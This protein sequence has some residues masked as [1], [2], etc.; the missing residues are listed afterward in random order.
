M[1]SAT[2]TS[3]LSLSC[4]LLRCLNLTAKEGFATTVA[5]VLTARLGLSVAPDLSYVRSL[6][7]VLL[8]GLTVRYGQAALGVERLYIYLEELEAVLSSQVGAGFKR[9]GEAY[10]DYDPFFLR[11]VHY[12]YTLVFPVVFAAVVVVWT[13]R[14]SPGLPWPFGAFTWSFAEYFNLLVTMVILVSIGMY[15]H[16]FHLYDRHRAVNTPEGGSK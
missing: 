12:L 3:T 13:W 1:V 7:W 10:R 2:A 16:A 15:L 5:D 9:E 4:L 11:W 8:L 14:Q 6:L